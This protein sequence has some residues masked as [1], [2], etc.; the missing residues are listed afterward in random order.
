MLNTA[1][2]AIIRAETSHD[3]DTQVTDAQILAWLDLECINVRVDLIDEVPELYVTVGSP[4]AI[5]GTTQTI[6]KPADFVKLVVLEKLVDGRYVALDLADELYPESTLPQ[7][8]Y[9][10]ANQRTCFREQGDNFIVSPVE[11]APGTYRLTY[12]HMF[13]AG[14]TSLPVPFGF[15]QVVIER[16]TEHVRGRH[17]EDRSAHERKAE[18][19]WK[20]SVSSLVSRTGRHER[21]PTRRRGWLR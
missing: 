16:A 7:F 18:A 12:G 2:V 3:A 9:Y 20:R 17:E 1:A 5:S 8:S 11:T 14:Y 10:V 21:G 4:T 13:A 19:R 15:E 6:S